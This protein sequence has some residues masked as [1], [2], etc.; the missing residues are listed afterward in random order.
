A[1]ADTAEPAWIADARAYLLAETGAEPRIV[2]TTSEEHAAETIR[3]AV[4]QKV[5]LLIAAGGDGTLRL[6]ASIL[7]HSE[8]TLGILPKGTVNVLA[9]ELSIPLDDDRAALQL[10]LHGKTRRIDMGCVHV[11]DKPDGEHFLIMA[12][13]GVDAT[14]VENVDQGVKGFMGAG[15]YVMSGITTLAGYVPPTV[16]LTVRGGNCADGV[17][18][19][20]TSQAFLTVITNTVLYGGDFRASPNALLDDGLLDVV[21]FDAARDLPLPLQR[22]NFA[23]Q[24]GLAAAAL[25]LNDPDVHYVTASDVEITCDPPTYL[26]VDG[27]P[28]GVQGSFRI[29]TLPRAL[30]VRC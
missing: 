29:E 27:D 9:R 18:V 5:P 25:H 4:A 13:L 12:S 24:F 10:A 26:Q 28:F 3:A 11:P 14:A 2:A 15:A 21:V 23:K 16:T 6:A 8:T 7:A 17:A 1:E 20:R 19:T 30:A 22:A